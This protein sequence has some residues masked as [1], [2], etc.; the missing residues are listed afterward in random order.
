[1]NYIHYSGIPGS[2]KTSLCLVESRKNLEDDS[3]VFWLSGRSLDPQRFSQIMTDLSI[4]KASKFHLLNFNSNE[5]ESSFENGINQIIRMCNQLKSTSLI[6][7][8]DWDYDME[9]YEKSIRINKISELVE[10]SKNNS[11]NVYLTSKSYENLSDDENRYSARAAS[12]L[13]KIGFNNQIIS[14]GILE[15]EYIIT[16]SNGNIVFRIIGTGIEFV[17]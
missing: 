11:I 3:R 14:E 9:K 17:E 13:E 15:N 16:A 12:D 7:I 8:D 1:M 2:G 6:I 5:R 10:C 4:S